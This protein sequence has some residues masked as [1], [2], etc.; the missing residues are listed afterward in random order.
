MKL[1]LLVAPIALGSLA[2]CGDETPIFLPF[3][4]AAVLDS[5]DAGDTLEDVDGD[6]A[7]PDATADSGDTADPDAVD[8]DTG[9]PD[10]GEPDA[11]EDDTGEP[12]TGEPDTREPD[13]GE[14][15][16]G[17]PD[18]GEP[19][20]GE[21]DTGEPDT[22]EPDTGEPDTGVECPVARPLCGLPGSGDAP[23]SALDVRERS[24]VICTAGESLD[25]SSRITD[26]EWSVAEAPVGSAA[27]ITPRDEAETSYFVSVAGEHVIELTVTNGDG[28]SDTAVA[29]IVAS[30]DDVPDDPMYFEIV[31]STPG[32]PDETDSGLGAG[33]DVDIHLLH[34]HGCWEDR[35]WDCHYRAREPDWPPVG[36]SGNPVLAIDD[37]DGAGPE[38]IQFEGPE[39]GGL[40]TL[41]A[42]Y[43]DD[44]DYGDSTVT[45]RIYFFG[46]LMHEASATLESGEWWVVGSV[47][48]VSA[49][50]DDITPLDLTYSD[51]PP[52][53][54]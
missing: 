25:G 50:A 14:P 16:I 39:F 29:T 6:T 17:E 49:D 22:G 48:N 26:Y 27:E 44:H 5:A 15:N 11:I 36:R 46:T 47:H 28:C 54:I 34:A 8:P 18:T 23:S 7:D 38:A 32:D 1:A 43:Y 37:T 30:R 10:T 19:D 42:H 21:A 45:A 51:V 35:V 13:I 53:G 4:D 24:A 41:A 2:A 33:S 52:C 12:D 9:E 31:W 20:T 40:Y 3:S